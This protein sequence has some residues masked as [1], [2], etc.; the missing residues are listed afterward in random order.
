MRPYF[1]LYSGVNFEIENPV[2]DIGGNDGHFLNYYNVKKGTIYDY[3]FQKKFPYYDYVKVDV[4]KGIPKDKKFKT[5]F[6]MELLEHIENPLYLLSDV[7]DVLQDD[8]I[9]Y[10]SIPYTKIGHGHHHVRRWTRKE[11]IQ[12]TENLGFTSEVIQSRRRFKGLG[13]FLPHCWLV[14]KLTKRLDNTGNDIKSIKTGL[15][16]K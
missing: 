8:G 2:L 7:Y 12:Q 16:S 14:L 6:I 10:I 13:F 11:I 4:S 15:N 5:I 9:C 3:Y 1:Q